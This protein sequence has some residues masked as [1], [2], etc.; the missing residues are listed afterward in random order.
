MRFFALTG[1]V[2]ALMGGPAFACG[3]HGSN[4][5][6]DLNTWLA[7]AAPDSGGWGTLPAPTVTGGQ[8][9]HDANGNEV[10]FHVGD[11]D[12]EIG[13]EFNEDGDNNGWG[14]ENYWVQI[15]LPTGEEVTI[16]A[17]SDMFTA[18]GTTTFENG[19]TKSG[20]SQIE[21]WLFYEGQKVIR[22]WFEDFDPA[23]QAGNA[24]TG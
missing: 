22:E 10:A 21:Y 18:G 5:A 9:S 12:V 1:L 11:E 24:Y 2:L 4:A 15:Q 20:G 6:A 23:N 16:N 14:N 19:V 17:S 3:V 13:D 7:T 8:S